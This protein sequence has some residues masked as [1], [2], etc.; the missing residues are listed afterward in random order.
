VRSLAKDKVLTE[1]ESSVRG[2]RGHIGSGGVADRV[3]THLI[4]MCVSQS[5]TPSSN[6]PA[7]IRLEQGPPCL[8]RVGM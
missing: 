6:V 1:S 4:F 5:R 2:R 8:M 7:S 3:K